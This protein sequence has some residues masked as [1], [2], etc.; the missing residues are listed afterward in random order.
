M[1]ISAIMLN[2]LFFSSCKDNGTA[3]PAVDETLNE[4]VLESFSDNLPV[5]VYQGLQEKTNTLYNNVQSLSQDG[6]TQEELEACQSAWRTARQAWEQSEAFLFGPV[7]TENIDPRIDTWPVNFTDLDAQLDGDHAFT[8][9]YINNLED[10]LKGFHPVE[11][12]IFGE[13]GNKT[14]GQLTA[15]D[16]E[17]LQGLALNLKTLTTQLA[18]QWNKDDQSSYYFQFI[19]A[20][21]GSTTYGTQRAAFE[22]MVNAMIDICDEV[23]NGKLTEPF[24]ASD[25]SL[26]ESP[27]SKNSFVDFTNNITGVQ[28]V[29]LGKYSADGK[30]LEDMVRKN[31]LQLDG[32]IKTSLNT[33]ISSLNG[34]SEPFGQ[35]IIDQRVQVQNT[36][37]AV[38]DLKTLLEEK[39]LP[40][41]QQ[42]TN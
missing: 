12:L 24:V 18:N 17:Y 14:A 26:E 29:Y 9:A 33:A 16:L 7:S 40:Y 30:G 11:Y 10:A 27:F 2:M 19:D 6:A 22:E 25:P 21:K 23:A 36:I 5:T 31:N 28:D 37:D 38:N 41:V 32:E 35:A 1:T 13:G 3:T 8:E 34:F 39:L 15:R 42:H 20:G 4:E